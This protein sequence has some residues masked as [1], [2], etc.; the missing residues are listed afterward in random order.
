MVIDA[1]IIIAI[2][3]TGNIMLTNG[4]SALELQRNKSNLWFALLNTFC[5]IM[6]IMAATSLYSIIYNY[7]LYLYNF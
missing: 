1:A 3:L 6:V 4:F 7:I 2:L 5:N